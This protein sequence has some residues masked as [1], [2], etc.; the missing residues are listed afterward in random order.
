MLTI[1]SPNVEK[2]CFLMRRSI[3]SLSLRGSF[4]KSLLK[5]LHKSLPN[6]YTTSSSLKPTPSLISL[7]ILSHPPLSPTILRDSPHPSL[8]L[9]KSLPITRLIRRISLSQFLPQITPSLNL[10]S[11]PITSAT[12]SF[13]NYVQ[14]PLSNPSPNLFSQLAASPPIPA[15]ASGCKDED[16][17]SSVLSNNIFRY[18]MR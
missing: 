5:S 3:L 8:P 9:P 15:S 13:P 11:N 14:N 17:R 12:P 10:S 18:V 16:P 7:Q 6:S 2:H 1:I 4:T